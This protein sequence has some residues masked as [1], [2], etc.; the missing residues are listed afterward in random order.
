MGG[1]TLSGTIYVMFDFRV[2]FTGLDAYHHLRICFHTTQLTAAKDGAA[3][4]DVADV[5]IRGIDHT[6]LAP[7]GFSITLTATKYIAIGD[8]T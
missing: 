4:R 5:D 3:Y 8:T 6:F 7:E 1:H 2:V